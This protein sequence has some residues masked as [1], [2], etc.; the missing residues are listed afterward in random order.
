MLNIYFKKQFRNLAEV[1]RSKPEILFLSAILLFILLAALK[2]SVFNYV[3]LPRQSMD[4][5]KDKFIYT[6]L[7]ILIL[8]PLLSIF[9]TSKVLAVFYLLQTVYILINISYYMYFHTYFN[10]ME[11]PSI[12]REGLTAVSHFSAPMGPELL[13]AFI[14][15]PIFIF[16]LLNYKRCRKLVGKLHL[17]FILIMMIS[18]GIV[19]KIEIDRYHHTASILQDIQAFYG[20]SK[21]VE[22][23]GTVANN[24]SRIY[25]HQD[26]TSLVKSF[27]YGKEQ[28][29]KA[30]GKSK[31]NFV[32]IQVE[33]LDAN[34]INKTHNGKYIA[35][36]LH[37]LSSRSVFYPYT[38]SYHMGGGT[39]D[40]E[41]SILNSIQPLTH[42]PAI[43]LPDYTYPN[44]FIKQ[45]LPAGYRSVAFHG[46]V[47]AFFNRDVAFP[48][49]GFEK[50]V[51]I[52]AM[53]MTDI[54]W[55]APDY[56]VFNY[57]SGKLKTLNQPFFSYT[58]TMTSHIPFTIAS[59]YYDN[60]SYSDV[61]DKKTGNYFNSISY[62]DQSIKSFVENISKNFPN[63]YILI[64][65]DH[66]PNITTDE[67]SQASFTS[68]DRYF[69]FVPLFIITPDHQ[70]RMEKRQVASFLD[71]APTILNAAG[72]NFTIKS[73]GVNLL[74]PNKKSPP[75]PL[76][77]KGFDRETLF[78]KI[79]AA[80]K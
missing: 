19:T 31:P 29:G 45:L 74:D 51:D 6:L 54:G 61:K 76:G 59:R 42:Y 7:V 72:I 5:F 78:Q 14:D 44:S 50:F 4:I 9:K 32:I 34:A 17:Y 27:R 68:Q 18:A 22:S 2:I 47:G 40:V 10:V 21:I 28:S 55:G 75:I 62:V 46:N 11:I 36:F 15:L 56:D 57:E 43:K 38:L 41:F 80:P 25:E 52:K 48:K 1:L 30:S 79:N 70:I 24:I 66:T 58:I 16:I 49:M 37:A 71:I 8:S 13:I 64:L 3:I 65:G 26:F 73:D 67:Y 20:E 35:P 63:T 53:G 60:K 77:D 69:E 12:A 39:S 23:Y 33:S